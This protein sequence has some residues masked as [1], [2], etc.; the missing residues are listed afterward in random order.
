MKRVV[1]DS[2]IY[3]SALGIG[4]VADEAVSA[5]ME[6]EYQLIA[7]AP[8]RSEVEANLRKK[9]G[10]VTERLEMLEIVLWSTVELVTSRGALNLCRDPKD[11][12][13]LE[14]C[15]AGSVDLLVTGDKDLLVLSRF[16]GTR[17][18]TLRSFVDELV[19]ERH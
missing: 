16:E 19:A 9:F 6:G 15:L 5:G 2:N 3:I 12:H 8:I 4:G 17:I 1:L 7:S 10:W 13:L 18:V 11:N 14:T